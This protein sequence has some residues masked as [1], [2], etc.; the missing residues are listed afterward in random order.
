M[1]E[2]NEDSMVKIAGTCGGIL[3]AIVVIVAIFAPERA[4]VLGPVAASIALMGIFL[5]Y[6]VS[7]REG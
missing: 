1:A 7:K 2:D 6:F 5:G 4:E 3:V